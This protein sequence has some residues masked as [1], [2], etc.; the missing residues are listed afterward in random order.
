[1]D[2]AASA[3]N[4][5]NYCAVIRSDDAGGRTASDR[6]RTTIEMGAINSRI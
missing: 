3:G 4:T 6:R 5:D 1:L 2:I